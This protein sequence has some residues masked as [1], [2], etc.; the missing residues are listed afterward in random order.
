MSAFSGCNGYRLL[1]LFGATPAAS[2]HTAAPAPSGSGGGPAATISSAG[3]TLPKLMVWNIANL[4]GGF[5]YPRVRSDEMIGIIASVIRQHEP[6]ACVIL[7]VLASSR[8]I[9]KGLEEPPGL[10]KRFT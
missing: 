1:S 2:T 8:P 10:D 4:G 6:D 9:S 5:G 3:G 7:E